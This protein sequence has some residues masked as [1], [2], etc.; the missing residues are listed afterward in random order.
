MLKISAI[1][2]ASG[3][4]SRMGTNKLSLDY[5]GQTFLEHVL[6]LSKKMAFLNES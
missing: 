5:Q 3:N 4:S 1:I 6:K 2:M